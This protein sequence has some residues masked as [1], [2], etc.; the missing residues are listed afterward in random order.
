MSRV[1]KIVAEEVGFYRRLFLPEAEGDVFEFAV[2]VLTV[3]ALVGG[4]ILQRAEM[5]D[6]GSYLDVIE[7]GAGDGGGDDGLATV[8]GDLEL[9]IFLMDVLCEDIDAHGVV[10]A[11]HEGE[12]GDVVAI[13]LDEGIDGLGIERQADILPQI[14][15]MTPGTA[16]RAITDVNCQC[17][18]VGYFLKYY[19][20]IDVLQHI[21]L[22]H[23]NGV[24][25]LPDGPAR[26]WR[27]ASG[28]R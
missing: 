19:S 17:H 18:F 12:A 23:R 24:L 20:R 3:K 8:P 1:I 25:P 26:S 11:T 7:V 21:S 15:A 28:N 22:R 9:G 14:M 10:V 13:F 16:T 5:T 4:R 2:V 6:E 27:R